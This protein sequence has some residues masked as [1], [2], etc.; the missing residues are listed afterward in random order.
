MTVFSLVATAVTIGTAVAAH[1]EQVG[2]W[3]AE[4]QPTPLA[5]SVVLVKANLTNFYLIAIVGGDFTPGTPH[6]TAGTFKG[7]CIQTV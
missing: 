6:M 7:L 3:L 1:G 4:Q 2:V 5:T